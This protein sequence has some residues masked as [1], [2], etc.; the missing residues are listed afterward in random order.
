MTEQVGGLFWVGEVRDIQ[1]PDRAGKVKII[2]HGHHNVGEEPIPDGDLIW[3]FPV[4]NNSPSLN[5][6]GST[7]C[8]LPGSTVVGFWMDPDT[9]QIPYILG[10]VHKAGLSS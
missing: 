9:K 3:A 5:K 8:Y 2:I 6:I 10:S 4:M 7:S 1:D